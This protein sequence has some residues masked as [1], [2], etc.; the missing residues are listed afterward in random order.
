M[1]EGVIVALLVTIFVSGPA[2]FVVSM[3][4][5][6]GDRDRRNAMSLAQRIVMGLA[7]LA[8]VL[9]GFL[10]IVVST[11]SGGGPRVDHAIL[12]A[13]SFP[14]LLSIVPL[15]ARRA[16]MRDVLCAVCGTNLGVFCWIAGFSIGFLYL[17]AA[18]LLVAASAAGLFPAPRRT[19]A[20]AASGSR[21]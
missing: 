19:A 17:P 13:V 14:I 10:E 8:A 7:I 6:G 15:F 4:R 11:A 21:R 1:R 5:T 12:P 18:I 2:F 9:P 3:A 16:V 20:A